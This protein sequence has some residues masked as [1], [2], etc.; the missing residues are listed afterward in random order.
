M[1]L[2]TGPGH[3]VAS[4][5]KSPRTAAATSKPI[6]NAL[7]RE[8]VKAIDTKDVRY[9]LAAAGVEPKS[10]STEELDALLKNEVARWGKII[11]EASIRVD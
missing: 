5:W 9:R 6:V 1:W 8:L 11:K 2:I 3:Q 4:A 10:G 7:N